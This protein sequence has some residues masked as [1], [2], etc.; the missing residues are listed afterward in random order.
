MRAKYIGGTLIVGVMLLFS[1]GGIARAA[2]RS[3]PVRPVRIVAPFPPGG[4]ADL[5]ARVLAD[6]LTRLWGQQVIVENRSGAGGVIGTS[7]VAK[8]EPDGYTVLMAALG[9]AANPTLY[10][11]LPYDT[12]RDFAPIVLVAEVPLDIVL[13]PKLNVNSV[14]ELV[15]YVRA[16]PG[17]LNVAGAGVGSSAYWATE[18]FRAMA[19]V[20]WNAV[21]YRG[22]GPALAALLAGECQVM[23]NPVSSNISMVKSGRLKAIAVTGAKRT[24]LLPDTPTIAEADPELSDYRFVAWYG[25]LAPAGVPQSILA[26]INRDSNVALND[27]ATR[28]AMIMRGAEPAGGSAEEFSQFLR[29]E[30]KRYAELAEKAGL[31]PQ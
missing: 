24:S 9:Q 21:E 7:I 3:Y 31:E 17:Q 16:N 26:M 2:E 14:K 20:K 25:L 10:K 15:A 13:N 22:G 19:K 28:K 4:S 30:T 6:R 1:A 23:F 11:K 27:P 5:L 29:R 18:L 12:A 8:A